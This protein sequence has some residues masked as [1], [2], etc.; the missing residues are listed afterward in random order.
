MVFDFR[1]GAS[2]LRRLL[3]VCAAVWGLSLIALPAFA[4]KSSFSVGTS[5]AALT[6]NAGYGLGIVL[7][8]SGTSGFAFNFMLPGDY[9]PD[10]AVKIMFD[11]VSMVG[12]CSFRLTPSSMSRTRTGALFSG[13]LGGLMVKGGD[14]VNFGSPYVIRSKTYVLRPGGTLSGQKPGDFIQ[15]GIE[16][17]ADQASDTCPGL[18]VMG[19]E[20]RYKTKKKK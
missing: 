4:G 1:N 7:T 8:G 17:D 5:S 3:V 6:G 10:S 18:G 13:G 19:I 15:L 11:L 12:P 2:A 9:K 20:V 16:R 14:T